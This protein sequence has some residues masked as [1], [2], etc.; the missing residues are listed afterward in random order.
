MLYKNPAIDIPHCR[1]KIKNSDFQPK[2]A[3][4]CWR[5]AP[6]FPIGGVFTKKF[7]LILLAVGGPPVSDNFPPKKHRPIF[8]FISERI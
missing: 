5:K 3:G 4:E 8:L 7:E 1:T 6:P 2:K